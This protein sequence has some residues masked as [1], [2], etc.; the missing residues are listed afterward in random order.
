MIALRKGDTKEMVANPHT[1][2]A[3]KSGKNRLTKGKKKTSIKEMTADVK[4]E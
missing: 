3:Q 4:M 1:M 2:L